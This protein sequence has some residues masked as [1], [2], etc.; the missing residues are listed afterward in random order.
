M[1]HFGPGRVGSFGHEF[2]PDRR[3][4]VGTL[5]ADGPL[6]KRL[7]LV[8]FQPHQSETFRAATDLR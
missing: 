5:R 3:A 1:A 4:A 2:E 8:G 7:V 6:I